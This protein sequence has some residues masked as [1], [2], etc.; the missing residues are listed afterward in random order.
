MN[1]DKLL[2]QVEQNKKNAVDAYS[3]AEESD[4]DGRKNRPSNGSFEPGI[5]DKSK[6]S[7]RIGKQ[8]LFLCLWKGKYAFIV[9]AR[10]DIAATLTFDDNGNWR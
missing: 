5:W 8:C 10:G 4:S 1:M 2:F 3:R 6:A 9:N 7:Q